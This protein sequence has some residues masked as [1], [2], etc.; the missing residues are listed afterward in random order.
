MKEG[1]S[2][3][4][5]QYNLGIGMC[6]VIVYYLP[7]GPNDGNGTSCV[8]SVNNQEVSFHHLVLCWV[9]SIEGNVSFPRPMM[10]QYSLYLCFWVIFKCCAIIFDV[11]T[12]LFSRS[13]CHTFC[14]V[15]HYAD[16]S[17][18]FAGGIKV[19]RKVKHKNNYFMLLTNRPFYERLYWLILS[20]LK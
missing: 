18:I 20:L 7:N 17:Y 14:T 9:Y 1:D 8:R 11:R 5:N 19:N 13:V 10:T 6:V 4:I 2:L 12:T 16:Q 3:K 15:T